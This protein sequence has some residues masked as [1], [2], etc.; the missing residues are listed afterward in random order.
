MYPRARVI[1]YTKRQGQGSVHKKARARVKYTKRQVQ[2]DGETNATIDLK[3]QS[4][5]TYLA[6]VATAPIL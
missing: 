2:F 5:F 3:K 1:R 6:Q 4:R